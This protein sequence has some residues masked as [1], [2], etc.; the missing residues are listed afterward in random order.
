M[1]HCTQE[2]NKASL[3]FVNF[4][5]L[6]CVECSKMSHNKKY[7]VKRQIQMIWFYSETKSISFAGTKFVKHFNFDFKHV[8]PS[9]QTILAVVNKFLKT[10]CLLDV[11][12]SVRQKT[13]RSVVNSDPRN[14]QYWKVR[15]GLSIDLQEKLIVKRSTLHNILLKDL[16]KVLCK[17]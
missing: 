4:K 3:M 8:K 11:P 13:G 6:Y 1:P 9:K 2:H 17:I 7:I 12:H 15:R 5:T 16:K 10:G 14:M